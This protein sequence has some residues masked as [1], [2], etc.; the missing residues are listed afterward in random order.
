M[1]I[2]GSHITTAHARRLRLGEIACTEEYALLSVLLGVGSD[3]LFCQ[4]QLPLDIQQRM[5]ALSMSGRPCTKRN[6]ADLLGIRIDQVMPYAERFGIEPFW[7]Q[8]GKRKAYEDRQTY[9]VTIHLSQEERRRLDAYMDKHHMDAYGHALRYFMQRALC[10]Q[11]T[12]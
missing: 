10:D 1:E 8:S 12:P 11:S 6:V 5:R 4:D 9:A 7:I 3:V 2:F